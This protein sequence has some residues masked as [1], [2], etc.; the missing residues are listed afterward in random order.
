[1]KQL[2]LIVDDDAKCLKFLADVLQ[3][4]GHATLTAESGERAIELARS[5]KPGLILMDIQMPVIDGLSAVKVLKADH[6]TRLI[7][8]VAIT[9]LAMHDDRDRMLAA[10]FDGYLSKP[11]SVKEICSEVNRHLGKKTEQ[12]EKTKQGVEH[13]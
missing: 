10:G 9:A 12:A 11:A 8:V 6:D 5:A 7:P 4:D 1:M 3:A 13:G 2:I